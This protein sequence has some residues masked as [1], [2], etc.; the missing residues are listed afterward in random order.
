MKGTKE[1][2]SWR[3]DKIFNKS[4]DGKC[5]PTKIELIG[6]ESISKYRDPIFKMNPPESLVQTPSDHLGLITEFILEWLTFSIN[7]W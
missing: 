5:K 6:T 3:P 7:K 1:F 4:V 2:P